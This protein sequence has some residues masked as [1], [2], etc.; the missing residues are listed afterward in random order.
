MH[1]IPGIQA[2]DFLCFL[3]EDPR[4]SGYYQD[5]LVNWPRLFYVTEDQGT[6]SILGYVVA[7]KRGQRQGY[8]SY[9]GLMTA[10]ENAM[11]RGYGSQNVSLYVRTSSLAA[12]NLFAEKIGYKI[13]ETAPE[14]YDNGEDAYVMEK[15]PQGKQA[16]HLA[17]RFTYGG[18]CFMSEAVKSKL[19]GVLE[20][21]ESRE[22]ATMLDRFVCEFMLFVEFM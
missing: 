13:Q 8:I 11:I 7:K 19:Q 15:K 22:T 17:H 21:V 3:E 2:C 16:D 6:G 9:L 5:C 1:D 18:G 20:R 14:F 12:V 10:A 4:D